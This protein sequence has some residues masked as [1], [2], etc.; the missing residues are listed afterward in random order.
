MNPI[1]ENIAAFFGKNHVVS[2]AAAHDGDIWS[3]CCFYVP[4]LAAGRLIVL[5]ARKTR[6]GTLMAANPRIAGTVAGQPD[7]I[8]KISG[9][10]FQAQA[11]VIEDEAERKAALA[12]FYKAHPM[13]R[14]MKSDVWALDLDMVKFT[15]NKLVFAQKTLWQ[16][17]QA[18]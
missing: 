4:D 18:V 17:H 3:A 12:L 14:A 2:L 11:R 13:A 15:D 10:Q 7:A 16:R 1:P 8:T 5:T 6:H 9:I